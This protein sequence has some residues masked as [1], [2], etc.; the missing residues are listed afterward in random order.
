MVK[1]TAF[2][3]HMY[4]R[5]WNVNYYKEPQ[6]NCTCLSKCNLDD[7]KKKEFFFWSRYFKFQ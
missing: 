6:A 4:L 1:K 2:S 5:G 7:L 3:V